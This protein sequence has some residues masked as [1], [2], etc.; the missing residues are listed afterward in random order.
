MKG[1]VV[2]VNAS[3]GSA[4][5]DELD[6]SLGPLRGRAPVEV[7]TCARPPD[8]ERVLGELDGRALIVA[9]GDGSLHLAVQTAWRLGLTDE[10]VFGL[11][12]MGTGNDFARGLDVPTDLTAAAAAVASAEPV[13]LDLVATD[14]DEIVVNAAHAGLGAAAAER[15]EG[16]KPALGPLAYPL[17]ALI[18]GVR[19]AGY[20]LTVTADGV[21][22]HDGATLLVGIANA[23]FIGGGTRL[24]PPALPD[25]GWLDLIVVS[26][27]GGARV[28]FGAALRNEVH[29]DRDDV[30]HRRARSVTISGDPIR[31]DLDGEVTDE[32]RSRT[33]T[34]HP[35]AW[36]FLA[37]GKF[38]GRSDVDHVER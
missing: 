18:A 25:D 2:A 8:L 3:A 21:R 27:V 10:V 17:G 7:R 23:P 12:P 33:Y 32:V 29:L 31:H 26:A 14:A 4:D 35:G 16:L 28:A 6:E 22:V 9:G 20:R 15:S 19:E 13:A 30:V 36:R 38:R 37:P 34:L 11:L 5:T 1:F 24:V